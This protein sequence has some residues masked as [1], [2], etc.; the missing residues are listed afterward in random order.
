M[1]I[2]KKVLIGH[3]SRR[4]SHPPV[5]WEGGSDLR[6]VAAFGP[7]PIFFTYKCCMYV[8]LPTKQILDLAVPG[9]GLQRPIIPCLPAMI[10]P[11]RIYK[12]RMPRGQV[13]LDLGQEFRF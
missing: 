6:R 2:T 1:C 7:T 11:T 8:I 13:R 5:R 9:F 12:K 10:A 3:A 4:D